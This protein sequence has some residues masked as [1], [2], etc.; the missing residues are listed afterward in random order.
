M[1]FWKNLERSIIYINEL[2]GKI[3]CLL[4]LFLMCF[5]LYDVIMRYLFDRPSL[6]IWETLQFGMVILACVAGGYAFLHD[7]FVKL[8]IFYARISPRVRAIL[9]IVTFFFTLLYCA[10]LI[11]KGIDLVSM[12]WSIR[13]MTP[14]AVQL[15]VY[16]L[17]LLVPLAGLLFLLVAVQKLFHDIKTVIQ[18]TMEPSDKKL[19]D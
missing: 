2:G 5:G 18:G 1:R 17:K 15:P 8:D 10:V 19:V 16:P 12:S 11:W 13:E 7:S 14:S 9:D 6:W 3:G 4:V